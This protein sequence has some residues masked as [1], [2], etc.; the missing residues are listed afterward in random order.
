M[1]C[2]R[3]FWVKEPRHSQKPFQPKNGIPSYLYRSTRLARLNAMEGM[4]RSGEISSYLLLGGQKC[5]RICCTLRV[6]WLS[7]ATLRE[8]MHVTCV[9]L[10]TYHPPTDLPSAA[11]RRAI[12]LTGEQ[13][14]FRW[15]QCSR[16]GRD[17]KLF[18]IP[19]QAGGQ[20]SRP[21]EGDFHAPPLPRW[22]TDGRSFAGASQRCFGQRGQGKQLM[23]TLPPLP[24]TTAAF[25]TEKGSRSSR[26]EEE[27]FL[28]SDCVEV[29]EDWKMKR[30]K[31]GC[32][33]YEGHF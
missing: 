15:L 24:L 17:L 1:A 19:R 27:G 7:G 11:V 12:H 8:G 21:P 20:A 23:S 25:V 6:R 2:F 13:Q 5:L 33:V 4:F 9:W 14:P 16:A 22:G 26:Q 32:G 28:F 29:D 3:R 10:T 31:K 18:T 30:T